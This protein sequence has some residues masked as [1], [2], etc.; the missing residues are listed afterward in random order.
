MLYPNKE[1][2]CRC[3]QLNRKLEEEDAVHDSVVCGNF[4]TS[5]D[6]FVMGDST[7]YTCPA[8]A[9]AVGRNK[10]PVWRTFLLC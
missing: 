5:M 8:S 10:W 1:L 4:Q 2:R 6:E 7:C 9:C 3:V